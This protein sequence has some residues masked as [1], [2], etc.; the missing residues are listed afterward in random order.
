MDKFD[1]QFRPQRRDLIVTNNVF[2]LIGRE[3]VKKGPEKGAMVET[4]KRAI[5][6]QNISKVRSDVYF[7]TFR[8][9]L[10]SIILLDRNNY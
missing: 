6:L 1:R 7:G 8:H 3:K 4:V 5:P 2:L 10:S 9:L